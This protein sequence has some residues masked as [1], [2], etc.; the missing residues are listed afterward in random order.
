MN[1]EQ[2]L[3]SRLKDDKKADAQQWFQRLIQPNE[4]VGDLYSINYETA[5]VIIHDFY[6]AKVGGIPSLSFLIASR[7]DPNS[8]NIDFKTEDASFILLRVMDAASLPQDKEAERIRVETAQ[9]ISG[10]TEKHWDHASAMDARTKNLLGFAGVQCRIIGTFFLE[11]SGHQENAP[12]NLK[13]GS[14]ISNYYPNRGLKVYKPNGDA[15]N[16][17]VNYID[18]SNILELKNRYGNVAKDAKVQI[19]HVRY[20]S[21]NRKYQNIDDVPV[22][23]HPM[24]LL[25]QKTALFGM[26]RTG[27]SNTTKIIAKSVFELRKLRDKENKDIRI[28]QIIFDPNGEYANENVQDNNSA[29]KNVWQLLPDGIKANEVITYGITK[30]PNDPDRTLML[31]NFFETEN[32]QT[33]KEIIDSILF[34]D[35][36]TY[37]KN[38]CQ[39]S[40]EPPAANDRSALTRHNRRVLAYKAMLARAGFTIPQN[41]R[42]VT[43]GLFN[44]QLRDALQNS[45]GDNAAEYQSAAQIFG[46]SAPTWGQLANAFETLDKFM[47]DSKSGYQA[48]ET[49]YVNRANSSGD[50]WADEDLKKIIGIFQY[51]NGTRKIGKAA[52]QHSADTTSD[53]A[54]DI[55]NHLV[56]G[57]L[58][59]IDQS[60]GEPELNKSSAKRI[61]TRIFKDNQRKFIHGKTDIPEILVYLEEAHNILPAGN[62]LD[63]TDV[64]VRTAKEGSK[65]RI[66]M[67]YATQEV[68]SIQKNILKNTANWFISHLNNTDETKE[69][70]KYYDFIDFEPS[71]RRAQ[72]KGFLRVKTLSNLFVIPVQ[73]NKFEV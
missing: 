13:F 53:Y 49:A 27:K 39:V 54:E 18:P 28:G 26:T 20:A 8:S 51:P 44:Q 58:V 12:L 17:I 30:H 48:F 41:Q 47:R 25:N 23:I 40:F 56:Q 1:I 57:K 69:L 6:R 31:L 62:D 45:T 34:E 65:Y 19:G 2:G 38:F 4:Y 46:N 55:Y 66:G 61:M 36:T 15:L 9:R 32:L 3:I 37:I 14:D 59:I 43:T 71:I 21:T 68:S 35:S 33:G 10:E 72:D 24:D 64:W 42:P 73:V 67:V 70:C 60:S 50:R 16:S 22:Y 7:V 29:L 63:L 11:A 5:R 52:E